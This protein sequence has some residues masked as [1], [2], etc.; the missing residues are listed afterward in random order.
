MGAQGLWP[1]HAGALLPRPACWKPLL[2]PPQDWEPLTAPASH[3]KGF[4]SEG[5]CLISLLLKSV[6]LTSFQLS[7]G[8]GQRFP[9]DWPSHM[10]QCT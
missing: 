6:A 10:N 5:P 9:R 1:V 7:S 8:A 2:E 3:Q 4:P